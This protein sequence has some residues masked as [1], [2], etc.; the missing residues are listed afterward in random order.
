MADILLLLVVNLLH[1]CRVV[2]RSI[3]CVEIPNLKDYSSQYSSMYKNVV[4]RKH[5]FFKTGHY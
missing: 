3:I 1:V 5:R 4:I 2:V